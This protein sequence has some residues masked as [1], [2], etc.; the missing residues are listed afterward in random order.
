MRTYTAEDVLDLI[1]VEAEEM[2][3][4]EGTKIGVVLE[5]NFPPLVVPDADGKWVLTQW[6]KHGIGAWQLG[7]TYRVE[8][9]CLMV[10]TQ[11]GSTVIIEGSQT[12]ACSVV[13]AKEE[14][15]NTVFGGARPFS[16]EVCE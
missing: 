1:M 14:A 3:I 6:E 7:Y 16:M 15:L 2:L 5:T 8:M 4:M 10:K 13:L 11:D 9:Y 12:E